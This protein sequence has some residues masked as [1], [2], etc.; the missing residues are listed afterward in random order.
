VHGD[1]GSA[2]DALRLAGVIDG[3]DRWSGGDTL[4]VQVGDQLDR[5]DDERAILDWFET[6]SDQAW[7]A[8]GGFYPLIGNHETMNV[9][10][11]FRYVTPGGWLDFAGVAPGPNPPDVSALPADQHGRARA[12]SPGGPYA[13]L[14]AGHNTVQVIGDTVFVHGGVLTGHV[15]TGLERVNASVHAWMAGKTGPPTVIRGEDSVVWS[16][17]YSD[18]PDSGDCDL[19]A[20]TLQAIPAR[21]MVV[22]HTVQASGINAACNGLVYRV[23]VGLSDYYGGATEVLEIVGDSV[24]VLR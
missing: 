2:R 24:R 13:A 4:V 6:L 3:S 18:D 17:H 12:F 8:G 7:A 1:L 5:G 10:G 11:D 19:L 22:A 16:R 14:L 9:S 20:A 23:D 15:Q 21:R